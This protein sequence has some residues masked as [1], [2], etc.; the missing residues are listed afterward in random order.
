MFEFAI[1]TGLP[2]HLLRLKLGVEITNLRWG[3][4]RADREAVKKDNRVRAG[5]TWL[6]VLTEGKDLRE[7]FG[8]E[9]QR[10]HSGE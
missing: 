4:G 3:G 6:M 10:S 8:A 9:Q 1:S 7:K 5:V 2:L